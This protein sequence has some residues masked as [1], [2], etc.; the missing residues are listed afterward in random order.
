MGEEGGC[1]LE[2]DLV[3]GGKNACMFLEDAHLWPGGG[4]RDWLHCPYPSVPTPVIFYPGKSLSRSR[5][6]PLQCLFQVDYT[7]NQKGF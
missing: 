4:A 2:V 7:L 6:L 5:S 1:W 3:S